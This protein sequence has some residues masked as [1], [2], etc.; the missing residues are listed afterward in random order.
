MPPEEVITK[1]NSEVWA[2]INQAVK[3]KPGKNMVG[4]E[5]AYGKGL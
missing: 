3:V 5:I 4:S 1:L 2:L